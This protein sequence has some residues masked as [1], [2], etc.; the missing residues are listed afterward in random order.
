MVFQGGL[1]SSLLADGA[2]TWTDSASFAGNSV[3]TAY[4]PRISY[5]ERASQSLTL[6]GRTPYSVL[7]VVCFTGV[8]PSLGGRQGRNDTALA[9]DPRV[10]RYSYQDTKHQDQQSRYRGESLPTCS[11]PPTTSHHHHGEAVRCTQVRN[12][13]GH[14]LLGGRY[15]STTTQHTAKLDLRPITV[16]PSVCARSG[17]WASE[18]AESI[19]HCPTPPFRHDNEYRGTE[20]VA[21][22]TWKG[23]AE[24]SVGACDTN[25]HC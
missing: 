5:C 9:S 4:I 7:P 2:R 23:T 20:S 24:H 25:R 10:L 18:F 17:H 12:A 22:H 3:S 15:P 14:V 16:D 8:C 11:S 6:E 1:Q 13:F 19:W 21:S